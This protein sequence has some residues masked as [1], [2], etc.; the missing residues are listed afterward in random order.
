MIICYLYVFLHEAQKFFI[1]YLCYHVC[2]EHLHDYLLSLCFLDE[3]QKLNLSCTYVTLYAGKIFMI[4][5]YLY[6]FLH[7]AQMFAP[8]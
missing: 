2:W 8:F 3:A 7:E 4:I 5:C 1:L 6:V